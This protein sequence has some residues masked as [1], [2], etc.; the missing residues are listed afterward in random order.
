MKNFSNTYIFIFSSVMV[1]LVALLLSVAA[2]SLKP[3]QDK[4]IEVEKKMNIL[5]SI[6]IRS[7]ANTAVD[8]YSKY[9]TESF[10]ID[11]KGQKKEGVNAFTVDM[12]SELSKPADQRSLPVFVGKLDNGANAFVVPLRGK[13]LWGPI[14]GYIS[15]EKDLNTVYGAVF[16]HQGETP[17]LGAEISTPFFQKPFIGK[18]IFTD[19][20]TFSSIKVIKGGIQPGDEHAVDA[21]SGGTI[22]SKGLEAM[23]DTCLIEYKP[24]FLTNRK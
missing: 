19:S 8:L 18:K 4:N 24:Y 21:V 20:V 10:V 14:W 23:L 22:T 13:G 7:D 3:A 11:N 5:A 16:D 12:K 15:F 2:L 1:I 17:G 9:V 6:Q